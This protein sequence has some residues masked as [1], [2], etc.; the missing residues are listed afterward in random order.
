M[1]I[2]EAVSLFLAGYFS[3]CSRATKTE[4][5]YRTDL[6]QF[7][8]HFGRGTQLQA[9][10]SEDLERWA[11]TLT[12]NGY[13]AVS[14]RRKFA[15]ARVFFNYWVRKGTLEHS[16][17]WKIRLDLAREQQLPRNIPIT[18]AKRLLEQAWVGVER[19]DAAIS[20]PRDAR[21]LVWRNIAAVEVLFAT[22]MRVGELVS[23]TLPDWN[24]EER[25]FIVKG[26]GARQRLALL[27]D[28]RSLEAVST[29]L[30]HR[31]GMR[32]GHESF[33][34]N[35]AGGRLSSQGVART[36]TR[37]AEDAGI[38]TRLTP[39]MIRHT[40][41]TLLLRNGADIRVVQEVLGHSSIAMTQRYT[42]VSKEHLR[43]TLQIHHPN[44]HLAINT[45]F[46]A[47]LF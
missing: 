3:T 46:Q 31:R 14:V 43:A 33:L 34:V 15:T 10:G 41:A 37:L 12:G 24:E 47:A 7:Q 44:H 13:A 23:L 8:A 35:A 38:T 25:S 22:G 45:Y 11:T 2:D 30:E 4:A 36:L 28:R 21:F 26:K 29:Y 18:E 39:H 6:A 27:T 42:H 16:P 5:A 32:L 17:F 19:G 9:V 1:R 40:V 20:T